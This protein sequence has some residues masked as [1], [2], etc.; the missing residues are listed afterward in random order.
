MT[1][2]APLLP[3]RSWVSIAFFT[4]WHKYCRFHG[5]ATRAEYW[6]FFLFHYFTTKGFKLVAT[7]V[8]A[9]LFHKQDMFDGQV[10]LWDEFTGRAYL[11][12]ASQVNDF[13]WDTLHRQWLNMTSTAAGVS[14]LFILVCSLLLDAFFVLPA[15]AVAVRRLHDVGWSGIWASV[16]LFSQVACYGFAAWT[17]HTVAVQTLA[18]GAVGA[19]VLHYL[20]N[21][22]GKIGTI[23][24]G[25]SAGL[26]LALGLLQLGLGCMDSKRGVN[27]YGF[28]PKYPAG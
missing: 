15:W 9:V 2:Q 5:R 27:R 6:S 22:V 24:V 21:G 1:E 23:C 10:R 17:A 11:K 4:L 3:S 26:S 28:S 25:I 7:P 13:I 8:C 20:L 18:D 14:V 16:G 12:S 19:D